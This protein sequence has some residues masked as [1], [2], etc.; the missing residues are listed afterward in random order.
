MVRG[1]FCKGFG[2]GFFRLVKSFNNFRNSSGGGGFRFGF[3]ATR[4][5]RITFFLL[6]FFTFFSFGLVFIT[7][8]FTFGAG[9]GFIKGGGGA[10]TGEMSGGDGGGG[11][12]GS[13]AGSGLG[14]GTGFGSDF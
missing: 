6:G 3:G 4:A 7:G 12:I 13:G 10:G 2:A 1:A 8:G 9:A 5:T 14:G 11:L